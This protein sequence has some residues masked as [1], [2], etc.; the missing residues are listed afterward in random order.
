MTERL[1]AEDGTPNPEAIADEV[2]LGRERPPTG[3]RTERG[4]TAGY[5]SET[6]L[7]AA[8][9]NAPRAGSQKA[10]VLDAL[11]AAG[12]RGMTD[13][14][15]H[16]QLGILRTAAGTRR[17]DL[18]RLGLCEETFDRRETDTRSMAA[19]HRI[20]DLGIQVWRALLER[21]A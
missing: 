17:K 2:L 8:L 18:E 10:R 19:V 1:F 15:L 5:S 7:L 3:Q 20:T 4:A 6:S 16:A 14:E 13:Y 11:V 9:D 21:A 12:A